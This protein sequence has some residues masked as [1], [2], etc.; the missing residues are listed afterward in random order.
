MSRR[1]SSVSMGRAALTAI[2]TGS[3]QGAQTPRSSIIITSRMSARSCPR[4]SASARMSSASV[5][6]STRIFSIPTARVT[7]PTPGRP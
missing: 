2:V 1:S 3:S 6:G 5:V 7:A 4:A